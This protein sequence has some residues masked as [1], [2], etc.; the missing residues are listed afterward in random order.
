MK[1]SKSKATEQEMAKKI[2]DWLA[3]KNCQAKGAQLLSQ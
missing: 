2:T 1:D 3:S